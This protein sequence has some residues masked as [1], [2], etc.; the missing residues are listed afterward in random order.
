MPKK[1]Q[2]AQPK[3]QPAKTPAI[4]RQF[5]GEVLSVSAKTIRVLVKTVKTHPKYRKQF[6]VSTKFAVHDEKGLAKPGDT[7]VFE[8]C[9]PMSRTKR[10]RLIRVV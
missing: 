4:H 2:K 6:S 5:S 10:W 7:V 3:V 1:T 9:R 8:E